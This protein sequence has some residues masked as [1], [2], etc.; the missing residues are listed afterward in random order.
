MNAKQYMQTQVEV[1][2]LG[3]RARSLDLDS[4]LRAINNAENVMPVLDPTLYR[5]AALNLSSI[6]RLAESLLNVKKAYDEV[7]EA[8]L[9]TS[10]SGYMEKEPINET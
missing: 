9:N 10:M 3:R 6:K 7:W 2:E 8:V 1:I 4:F 5:K